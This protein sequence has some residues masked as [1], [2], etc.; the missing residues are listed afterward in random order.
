MSE[1]L[2]ANRECVVVGRSIREGFRH[3]M[4]GVLMSGLGFYVLAELF[5][6]AQCCTGVNKQRFPWIGGAVAQTDAAGADLHLGCNLEK[7]EPKRIDLRF[8]PFGST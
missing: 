6:A 2:S 3:G 8:G 5:S 4:A 1:V 7:P